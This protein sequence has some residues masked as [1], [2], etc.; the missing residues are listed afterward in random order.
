MN[1]WQLLAVFTPVLF[2]TYQTF[3]KF[4]PKDAPIFLVN[5]IASFVGF[6]VMLG[7]HFAVSS[8]I[9]ISPKAIQL[10][11]VIGLLISVGN[12]LIIKAYALGAPQSVFTS[13]FY[14]FLIIY[15]V[16]YGFV[17]WHERF[18]GIQFVGLVCIGV[19]VI[20]VSY[21]RK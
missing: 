19:G 11:V 6:L 21:F 7:F 1:T 18:H 10:S 5:A 14:P 17:L 13:L 4:L 2:V 8:K 16:M 12:F 9:A 15:G 20:L 3:S